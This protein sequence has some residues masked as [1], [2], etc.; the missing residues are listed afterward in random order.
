MIL[1]SATM[2][3]DGPR[4][5][6]ANSPFTSPS[7][8]VRFDD[9][10]VTSTRTCWPHRPRRYLRIKSL[11]FVMSRGPTSARCV[12][13]STRM[14]AKRPGTTDSP[15]AST[16]ATKS[17]PIS[18][19]LGCTRR[20]SKVIV[21]KPSVSWALEDECLGGACRF[22]VCKNNPASRSRNTSSISFMCPRCQHRH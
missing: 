4:S 13:L 2:A 20:D 17:R 3:D 1:E 12:D 18:P 15:C 21:T 16:H 6:T 22:R 11:W 19:R 14:L 10:C 5:M 7:E 8:P 9:E